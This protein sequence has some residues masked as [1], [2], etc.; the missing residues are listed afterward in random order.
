M[1]QLREVVKLVYAIGYRTNKSEIGDY[2][3]NWRT[4]SDKETIRVERNV[5]GFW[6]VYAVIVPSRLAIRSIG[7]KYE[8]RYYSSKRKGHAESACNYH[9]LGHIIDSLRQ[10]LRVDLPQEMIDVMESWTLIRKM[11]GW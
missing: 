4:Y 2:L 1:K 11:R 7:Y 3:P 10:T 6:K 9:H 5:D 8:V